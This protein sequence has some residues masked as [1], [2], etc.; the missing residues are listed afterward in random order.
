MPLSAC[1]LQSSRKEITAAVDGVREA[2]ATL[3][4]HTEAVATGAAPATLQKRSKPTH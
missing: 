1:P 4:A 2:A 3:A